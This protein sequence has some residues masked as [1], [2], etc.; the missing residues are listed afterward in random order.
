[1]SIDFQMKRG[2]SKP[3]LSKKFMSILNSKKH[4]SRVATQDDFKDSELP[5]RFTVRLLTVILILHIVIIGGITLR[6]YLIKD[7]LPLPTEKSPDLTRAQEQTGVKTV[8]SEPVVEAE[9]VETPESKTPLPTMVSAGEKQTPASAD[10]S[11][12]AM[13]PAV[14]EGEDLLVDEPAQGGAT[15]VA[16]KTPLTQANKPASGPTTH[17]VYSGDTWEKIAKEYGCDVQTLKKV[18]NNMTLSS[19]ANVIIPDKNGGVSAPVVAPSSTSGKVH[20]LAKGE[21]LTKVAK[22]NKTTVQKLMQI[23]GFTEKDT[24]RLKVGQEIKLP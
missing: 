2:P 19:N 7:S 14:V 8:V 21:T 20:K 12:A 15:V 16:P 1:M 13:L 4:P 23:N 22:L 18:N 10:K 5:S 6:G 11:V 9:I 3:S 24:R 17:R